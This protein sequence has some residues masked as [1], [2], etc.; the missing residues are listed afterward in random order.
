MNDTIKVIL[1]VIG[2]IV[3]GYFAYKLAFGI[4]ASL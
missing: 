3:V 1:I 2:A 4:S